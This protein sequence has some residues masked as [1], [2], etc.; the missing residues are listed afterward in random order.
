MSCRFISFCSLLL[1]FAIA[2]IASGQQASA[3][4]TSVPRRLRVSDIV[5]SSLITAKTPVVYP[6]AARKTAVQ[7][8]VVLK[9]VVAEA[10]EVKEVSVVSG[11]PLLAQAAADAVKQWRYKPYTVDGTPVEMETQVSFNF[12]LNP[13]EHTVPPLGSFKDETY[14]NEF[15]D[16]EYPLSSDW[17]RETQAM[18]KKT[19]TGGQTPHILLAAVHIPQHAAPPEADTSFVLSARESTGLNCDRYLQALA[20]SLHS[21]K[22]AKQNGTV[23]ALTIAGHDFYRA[24][25]EFREG[26]SYRTFL[27][28][29]SKDY[30]LQWNIAGLSKSAVESVVSTLNAI[31]AP[32]T[33]T[34]PGVLP[35][36]DPTSKVTGAVTPITPQVTRVRVA[37]GVTS[38]MK[39]KDA[40]PVYP[41]QAKYAH[42]Q[43]MVLMS[44]VINKNGEVEDLEV[45]DGP[46][47]LV[48]SAVNAVRQWK[49]RPYILNGKPVEVSTQI[50]VKYTLSF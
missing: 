9:L 42:I 14:S 50:T 10:G 36:G 12:H 18:Q 15:F 49:Y 4:P 19:P 47:E 1:A 27:C 40:V 5:A 23:T 26:P 8:T 34:A 30:L 29:R 22:E 2:P 16:F 39:I 28:T 33:R 41:E 46:I 32:Q 25:F 38:G 7:G 37:Q 45:L 17:V 48:V 21:R 35:A 11:D 24:D 13:V 43:G 20:D 6:D 31:R 3:A 44:V